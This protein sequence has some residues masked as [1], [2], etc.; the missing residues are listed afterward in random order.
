MF[1]TRVAV[2]LKKKKKYLL[3]FFVL[4]NTNIGTRKLAVQKP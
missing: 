2:L 3:N 1:V 4:K